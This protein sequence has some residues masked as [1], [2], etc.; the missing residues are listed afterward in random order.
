MALCG[1]PL[2]WVSSLMHLGTRVTNQI[3]GCQQDMNQKIAKYIDKNCT[4]LQEFS[5][6]HPSTK[7]TLN[8][9]YIIAT[10]LDPRYGTSSARVQPAL[11]EPSIDPSRSWLGCLTQLTD[12]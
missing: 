9:I 11:K 10:F 12:T 8:N 6:A 3:D 1:N 2:P 5:F 4:L 7:I